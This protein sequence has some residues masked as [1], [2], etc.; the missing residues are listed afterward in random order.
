MSYLLPDTLVPGTTDPSLTSDAVG[1]PEADDGALVLVVP[2]RA[3]RFGRLLRARRQQTDYSQTRLAKA[4][5][6]DPSLL[7]RI[8]DG[9]KNPPRRDVVVALAEMLGLDANQTDRF[10]FVAGYAPLLDWQTAYEHLVATLPERVAEAARAL[11]SEVLSL[12]I[13]TAE[14]SEE[15][16]RAPS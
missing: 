14:P 5:G 4:I 13:L 7:W 12:T 8:E 15:A 6:V 9:Q 3:V 16:A 11:T 2:S 1:V 10:L